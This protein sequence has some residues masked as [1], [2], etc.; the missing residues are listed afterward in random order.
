[1]SYLIAFAFVAILG[2]LACALFFMM[3]D[4]TDGKAKTSNMARALA[5]RV[6]LSVLLFVCILLAWKFGLI[7]PTGLPSGG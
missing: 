6:G 2:S 3:K 5:V 7:Q 1:M 4:G